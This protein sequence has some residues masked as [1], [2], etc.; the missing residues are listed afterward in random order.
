RQ[1]YAAIYQALRDRRPVVELRS[2]SVPAVPQKSNA[3][4]VKGDKK[5]YERVELQDL[6]Y[7]K[8]ETNGII[9]HT[10]H[11]KYFTYNTLQAVID[12]LAGWPVVRIHKSIAVNKE[13]VIAKS[14]TEIIMRDGTPHRIG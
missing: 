1:L 12:L 5:Y 2:W 6:I 4:F 7:I 11:G 14:E 3:I 8:A 9:L 10:I 13:H